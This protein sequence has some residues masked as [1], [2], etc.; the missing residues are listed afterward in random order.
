[1]HI[2]PLYIDIASIVL[3]P[4]IGAGQIVINS[5][6]AV[7]YQIQATHYNRQIKNEESPSNIRSVDYWERAKSKQA[8]K[9]SN[10]GV[11][12]IRMIPVVGGLVR[13]V[14][15]YN[16]EKQAKKPLK[17]GGD[18]V[19]QSIALEKAIEAGNTEAMIEKG[20]QYLA[21]I[22]V[23]PRKAR[24][25]FRLAALSGNA[26]G[27]FH[28]YRY[29]KNNDLESLATEYLEKAVE[30][31]SS[32]GCAEK[33]LQEVIQK[34]QKGESPLDEEPQKQISE[35][36]DEGKHE[37]I[38]SFLILLQENSEQEKEM[39]R[40]LATTP[41]RKNLLL[42]ALIQGNRDSVIHELS[43]ESGGEEG[44]TWQKILVEREYVPAILSLSKKFYEKDRAAI[45]FLQKNQKNPLFPL[46]KWEKRSKII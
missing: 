31:K 35:S 16:H 46:S 42:S 27:Y 38:P 13:T 37:I 34:C 28:L 23:N 29:Y 18:I 33:K 14:Y 15:T 20:K 4:L 43:E 45:S 19:T 3:G 24:K 39:V 11:G 7:F 40:T 44:I 2:R 41:E 6:Q 10:I 30:G 8:E 32:L 21:W 5:V 1:M 9:I 36:L 26:D 17:Q 25:F 22:P 12:C